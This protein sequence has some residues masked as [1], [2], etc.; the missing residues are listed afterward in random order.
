MTVARGGGGAALR[1]EGIRY[2][3]RMRYPQR[4]QPRLPCVYILASKRNGTLYVGV[5][6]DLPG[7]VRQHKDR[8]SPG[9]THHYGVSALVW[10]EPHETMESAISREK[11][12]KNWKRSW[13]ARLIEESNPLWN[14]LCDEVT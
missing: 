13:K 3:P 11:A 2:T 6:S 12:L 5:T 14:D 9:F 7:R 4:G 10:Y 1:G 8:L